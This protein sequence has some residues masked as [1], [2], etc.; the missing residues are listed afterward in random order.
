MYA[1]SGTRAAAAENAKLRQTMATGR[2][3]YNA[4]SATYGAGNVEWT[5]GAGRTIQ[6]PS[7]LPLPA[8][9]TR[10]FRV[11]PPVRSGSF[12]GDLTG[13]AGPRPPGAIA[14]HV[15]PLQLN[16]LD[17]GALNGAWVLEPAHQA[18]HGMLTPIINS[19]PR[20]EKG[21]EAV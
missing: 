11:Q 9:G 18:G 20:P 8:A 6:W 4:L 2:E 14:H 12:V 21:S 16:G 17:N 10:L 5:S 15:T 1:C 13:V 19:T 7:Q 3:W